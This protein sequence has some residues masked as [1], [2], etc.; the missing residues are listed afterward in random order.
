MY[1]K[2]KVT[3][4]AKKESF[5]KKKEDAFEISVKEKPERN[6]ANKRIIDLLAEHLEV[7]K[8]KVKI[9]SGHHRPNKLFSILEKNEKASNKQK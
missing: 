6:M 1:L 5:K 3:T 2:V 7:S 9:V 8:G 4:G